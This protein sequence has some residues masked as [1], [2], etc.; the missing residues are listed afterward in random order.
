MCG[1]VSLPFKDNP[2]V[3]LEHQA[4]AQRSQPRSPSHRTL[5]VATT[6]PDRRP[7]SSH[8]AIAHGRSDGWPMEDLTTLASSPASWTSRFPRKLFMAALMRF[9]LGSRDALLLKVLK[10]YQARGTPAASTDRHPLSVPSGSMHMQ[11][12]GSRSTSSSKCGHSRSRLQQVACSNTS[13]PKHYQIT[14]AAA[15][16]FYCRHVPFT[17]LQHRS[18][19]TG[20]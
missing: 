20:S 5:P 18:C 15:V 10:Q 2:Y 19:T 17:M 1:P 9:S 4:L 6:P 8:K 3:A 14:P 13:M 7:L 16:P 11:L 12:E